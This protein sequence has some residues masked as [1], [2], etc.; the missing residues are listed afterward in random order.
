MKRKF[1]S[2]TSITL[3]QKCPWAYWA[4][5]GLKLPD[6]SGVEA[7]FGTMFHKA[8][9]ERWHT[10]SS[11]HGDERVSRMLEVLWSDPRVAGLPK[12]QLIEG[13]TCE[14]ELMTDING[15]MVKAFLDIDLRAYGVPFP[16][17]IK[18][19]SKKIDARKLRQTKQHL[20]Y[21]LA[22]G[23][24]EFLYLLV[25]APKM[26]KYQQPI[27]LEEQLEWTPEV[28]W[29]KLLIGQDQ[30]MQWEDEVGDAT[31]RIEL[32]QFPTKPQVLCD[33]CPFQSSCPA[34]KNLRN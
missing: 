34:F 30:K 23:C 16:I 8:V 14:V 1:E 2:C 11:M 29:K 27:P 20:H 5:Y 12:V 24:D 22:L 26:Q 18:S 31:F 32:D 7:E 3:Y 10:R 28:Q 17:D 15:V 6:P 13:K 25:T 19:S 21:P 33:W 4:K 9:Y